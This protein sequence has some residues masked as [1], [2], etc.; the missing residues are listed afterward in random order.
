MFDKTITDGAKHCKNYYF[1]P[2][3]PAKAGKVDR[4]KA[5]IAHA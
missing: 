3:D 4:V 1:S 2:T 5:R